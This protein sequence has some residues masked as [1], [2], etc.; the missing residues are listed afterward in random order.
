MHIKPNI[1][2][3]F[4][5]PLLLATSNLSN[6]QQRVLT[7]IEQQGGF[8]AQK[9][10]KLNSGLQQ[11][12]QSR[13]A[14]RDHLGT[15]LIETYDDLALMIEDEKIVIE[16]IAKGDKA[17]LVEELSKLNFEKVATFGKIISGK[18]HLDDLKRLNDLQHLQYARPVYKPARRVGS[19]DSQG[20]TA[21]YTD[22]GRSSYSINGAGLKIGAL[23]DSYNTLNGEA[24]GI[25]SGDLPGAGNSNGFT[26]P[27]TV[28]KEYSSSGT[29]EARA[30]LEL[31]HDVAPGAELYART[32]FEGEADFAQGILDMKAAGCDIIVDDIGYFAEPFFQDGIIAQAV[33]SVVGKGAVYFAAAGNSGRKSYEVAGFSDSGMTYS[34]KPI[35]DFDASANTDYSQQ[36]TLPAGVS[37][38]ITLQWD[39]P[40]GSLPNSIGSAD[41]DMDIYIVNAGFTAILASSQDDNISTGDPYEIIGYTNNTGA[42]QQ[43]NLMIQH[44]T[45]PAPTYMKYV[46][47]T[48]NVTI[49]EYDTKSSTL[50]G[51]ANSSACIAVGSAAYYNTTAYGASP[52]A[53]NNFSA[54]GGTPIFFDRF[55]NS[56]ATVYRQKPEIIGPDGSNTTFFGTDISQDSD[57]YP[58]FFGTSA[59]APHVAAAG[60]LMM[61][62]GASG[63]TEIL[64]ALTNTSE[65]MDDPSTAGGDSGFDFGTGFG[66]VQV[67]NAINFIVSLPVELLDFAVY[68]EGKHSGRLIWRTASELNNKSFILQHS[69]NNGSFQNIATIEGKGTSSAINRYEHVVNDLIGGNHY[70]RLIQM[71]LDGSLTDHGIVNLQIKGKENRIWSYRQGDRQQIAIRTTTQSQWTLEV[72]SPSGKM[73]HQVSHRTE[74]GERHVTELPVEEWPRGTY[75]YKVMMAGRNGSEIKSG[76]FVV[77]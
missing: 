34:G 33:D 25:A 63:R 26:T 22:I 30:M 1:L 27:V 77:Q 38:Y 10:Q 73:V 42:T 37:L 3:S 70:F 2:L 46:C 45:G 7:N 39:D 36:L 65:D 47:W 61:E 8:K 18:I 58:N 50:I 60:I 28:L 19:V 59:A 54:A 55:G 35:H 69:L 14:R 12:N 43:I 66:M 44:Y 62:I 24:S 11:V 75:F 16:L 41:T 32:A 76:K 56:I 40:F 5:F 64:N 48:N 51:H 53:I 23:S 57:S 4:L 9:N 13:I 20:D 67:D 6:A 52:P 21:M 17:D 68:P 49:D 29:D 74:Q 31:I 15:R 72:F 71:D